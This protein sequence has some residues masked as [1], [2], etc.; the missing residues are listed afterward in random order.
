MVNRAVRPD[1]GLFRGPFGAR[2]DLGAAVSV[3]GRLGA[4]LRPGQARCAQT[5]PAQTRPGSVQGRLSPGPAPRRPAQPG[6]S[7]DPVCRRRP[8]AGNGGPGDCPFIGRRPRGGGPGGR[9]RAARLAPARPRDHRHF[10]GNIRILGNRGD[11]P[12]TQTHPKN[13]M[14]R[15][16]ERNTMKVSKRGDDGAGT[17]PGPTRP[18]VARAQSGALGGP[19]PTSSSGWGCGGGCRG[20]G[21]GAGGTVG[22]TAAGGDAGQGAGGVPARRR[23]SRRCAGAET[24]RRRPWGRPGRNRRGMN[25]RRATAPQDSAGTGR[26]TSPGR[27]ATS[28]GAA[29]AGAAGLTAVA[30]GARP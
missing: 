19:Q 7:A 9:R 23:R 25:R 30:T 6:R 2:P 28:P 18:A 8:A 14:R 17:P 27:T 15:K 10:L 12:G 11:I 1:G 26:E 20:Q 3:R 4:G 16:T 29:L 13:G 24:E 22:A 5:R 21:A